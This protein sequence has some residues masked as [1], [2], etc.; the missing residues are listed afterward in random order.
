MR[1]KY[2]ESLTKTGKRYIIKDISKKDEKKH[3]LGEWGKIAKRKVG[4]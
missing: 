1:E 2:K 4:L 3:L